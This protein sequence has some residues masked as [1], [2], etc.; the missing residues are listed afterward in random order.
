MKV[1]EG[2]S[3]VLGGLRVGYVGHAHDRARGRACKG[4]R[5]MRGRIVTQEVAPTRRLDSEGDTEMYHTHLF[6]RAGG[7]LSREDG[8]SFASEGG[9]PLSGYPS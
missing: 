3:S 9:G 1:I 4:R 6:M 5:K 2:S 8:N 7:R